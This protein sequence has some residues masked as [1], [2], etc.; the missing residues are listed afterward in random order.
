MTR[1]AN[2]S[3][4]L[5]PNRLPLVA[6]RR[7]WSSLNRGFL[8]MSSLRTRISSCKYLITSCWLRFIQPARQRS[9]NANGFT[10]RSSHFFLEFASI[11][12]APIFSIGIWDNFSTNSNI[13]TIRGEVPPRV[14]RVR[15]SHRKMPHRPPRKHQQSR[16]TLKADKYPANKNSINQ[17][18]K[19]I[20]LLLQEL[21][22]CM[23]VPW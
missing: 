11:T 13:W 18:L 8:P 2:R 6:S 10:A 5:R 1:L 14:I 16:M 4:V 20:C 12:N 22:I 3:S 9:T 15:L 7:R 23:F 19:T 21:L 17:I